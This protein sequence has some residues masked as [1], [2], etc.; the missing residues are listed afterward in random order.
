MRLNKKAFFRL[1][2]WIGIKLSILFFLVCFSG[3]LATLSHELDWLFFPEMRAEPQA[4]RV[5]HQAMIKQLEAAY[6][7]LQLV[8]LAAS[9]EAY[10]CDFAHM[11]DGTQRYF[12]FL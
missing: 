5:P 4:S 3:T 2:G 11:Y 10:L 12:V 9:N 1:H 6:P 7:D 8:Y